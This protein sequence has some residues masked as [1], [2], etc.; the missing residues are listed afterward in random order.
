MLKQITFKRGNERLV[1]HRTVFVAGRSLLL[2]LLITAP[3]LAQDPCAPQITSVDG[4][5]VI[6]DGEA[7]SATSPNPITQSDTPDYQDPLATCSGLQSRRVVS[8]STATALQDAMNNASCGD[9]IQLAPGKYSASFAIDNSCPVTAPV[10]I[11]GAPNFASTV[12]SGIT[13]TG[14]RTIVMG[15]NFS[16]SDARLKLGGTNN[17][18]IANRFSDWRT[19]AITPV[20]GKQGEIAYNE[21]FAP[22]PWLASEADGYPLRIGIRSGE[23]DSSTFHFGAWIHHNY[24]HDFPGKPDEN[25]YHSG[26][27]DAIEV[28]QTNRDWTYST[29]AGWYIER[30]LITRHMQGRGIVDLKCSGVVVRG[31]T[32]TESP[33][34]RIDIRAGVGSTLESNWQEGSGGSTV[35]GGNHRVVGNYMRGGGGIRVISGNQPWNSGTSGGHNQ[36]YR[37]LVAG[38]DTNSL[39]VGLTYDASMEAHPATGTMIEGHNGSDHLL[40]SEQQTTVR[41]STTARFAPAFKLGSSDVGPSALN[42]ASPTYLHCRRP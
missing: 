5:P 6:S 11:Q 12:T 35:H 24:F 14:S 1:G 33:D 15:I 27:S 18:V 29:P 4:Q 9:T 16:G 17:K 28:C 36:A 13:I 31:N 32:V 39:I 21:L 41:S 38:N 8:V 25:K 3:A 23:K 34:G 42:R 40:Q 19:I 10:I 26:Q 20:A 7:C 22:H 37:V 2:T 30:N